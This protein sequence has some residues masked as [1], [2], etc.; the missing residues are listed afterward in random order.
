MFNFH[1]ILR[2]SIITIKVCMFHRKK[3]EEVDMNEAPWILM[4]Q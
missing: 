2:I 3:G 1:L 4:S